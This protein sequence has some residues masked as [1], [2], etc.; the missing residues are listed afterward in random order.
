MKHLDLFSGLGVFA[1]AGRVH[2]WRTVAFAEVDGH[3]GRALAR[4]FPG[5]PN[6]GD[7][8]GICRNDGAGVT[9]EQFI[10]AYGK[11]DIITGGFPCVDITNAKH[12]VE[13]PQGIEGP[14]SGLWGE[15]WRIVC[16]LGPEYVIVE[17]A[18]A[19][20]F[21]GLGR[22]MGDLAGG[23]YDAVWFRISASRFGAPHRRVRTFIVAHANE[24]G[25]E[26]DVCEELARAF[27]GRSHADACRSGWWDTEPGVGRVADGVAA[28]R[29]RLSALGNSVVMPVAEYVT[30]IVTMVNNN[31]Q[32][33]GQTI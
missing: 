15:Y 17:N 6:L 16:E 33:I 25:L 29:E 22:I 5:V 18:S 2:G 1:R 10:K 20:T 7:V 19:L 24:S 27:E 9:T 30:G 28:K 8:R 11:P 21:R 13:R 3:C 14:E 23:G 26:G 32:T 31:K 12:A 4:E